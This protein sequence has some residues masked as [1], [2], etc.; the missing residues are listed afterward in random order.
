MTSRSLP[1][2]V[3]VFGILHIIF[4]TIGVLY[5]FVLFLIPQPSI[6]ALELSGINP[7]LLTYLQVSSWCYVLG[8][9]VTVYLGISLLTRRSAARFSAVIFAYVQLSW[10]ALS[11]VLSITMLESIYSNL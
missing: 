11:T 4:G 7:L 9:L 8:S 6:Q 5:S 10:L 3:K 1:T 2:C